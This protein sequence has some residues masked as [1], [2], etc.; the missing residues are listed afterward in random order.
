MAIK[1]YQEYLDIIVQDGKTFY[2]NITQDVQ[3]AI[4]RSGFENGIIL[5]HTLHTTT[6]LTNAKETEDS[7]EPVCFLVQ[8]EE[9]LLM[10]DLKFVL[11]AGAR[12]FLGI[13]PLIK[14]VRP[15]ISDALPETSLDMMLELGISLLK[16]LNG[17][18]HD[19]FDIR[20]TNMGPNERKN[21]E[22][23]LKAAMIK[24]F[25]LWAFGNG[26]LNLGKW[27]SILF[28]DFD[29][30]GRKKRKINIVLMGD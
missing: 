1:L 12:K 15:T 21:A 14:K 28:W 11:D 22:A 16:P 19:D 10:E 29:P 6:G 4:A 7:P 18:K 2:K 8:E 5:I 3:D 13:L 26:R 23:H 17:F 9:P 20:I 30:I 27:Q 24:E 25:V